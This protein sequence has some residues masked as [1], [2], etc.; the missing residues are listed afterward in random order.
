LSSESPVGTAQQE[1]PFIS[2]VALLTPDDI[3]RNFDLSMLSV[4]QE[5]RRLERKPAGIHARELGS[6]FSMWANT[7][8]D[9]GLIVVGIDDKSGVAQGLS[10]LGQP[11]LNNIEQTGMN[12][13][14]DARNET[15]RIAVVNKK[16]ESDFVLLIRVYYNGEKVVESVDGHVYTRVGDS[17]KKLSRAEIRQLEIDK[18]QVDLEQE[19]SQIS[20]PAEFNMGLIREFTNA[21][22]IAAA[23]TEPHSDEEIL[24]LRRLGKLSQ[25]KF[26]PNVAC[27][28]V[29][30]VDPITE[31]PGCKIRFLRYDGE[32]E[33]TGA[34]FNAVKDHSIEGNIPHILAR[35]NSILEEQLRVFSRLGTDGKFYTTQE[36]PR[37]AW[38]EAVVNACVHRS[39]GPLRNMVTFVKMFDDRLLIESPGGFPPF[40]TPENIYESHHPRNP[41]LM[42]ALK[43]LQFV[44]CANEGTRRM[45][46]TM[47][48][49]N[50]PSPDF[51]QRDSVGTGHSLVRVVLRN[52]IK[53]RRVWV[54]QDASKIIGEA[55]AKDLTEQE[56]RAVNFVAEHGGIS[57]SELQRLTGLHWP[58]S[59]KLLMKL[60][61]A[62]ILRHV[63]KPG[64]GRDPKAKFVLANP[65]NGGG[66][67]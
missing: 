37:E 50:L 63:H 43:Y 13:C 17:K 51:L 46:D 54:D 48:S 53:H 66:T 65:P 62:K 44:K 29:F 21:I 38:Y 57:V 11:H 36:Y 35:T 19:P 23:L 33:H 61:K 24:Q 52:D 4:L 60:V 9:G 16:G 26:T 59:K 31:F 41:Q 55:K 14:P 28:L 47:K 18:G 49:N 67:T 10:G 42:N 22:R 40:V 58:A 34:N 15:K 30:A 12:F 8:P 25:G 1:F 5:D 45:R 32:F 2:S 20:Y 56:H 6:Y 64:G 27:A 7:S 39:Y 3:Y